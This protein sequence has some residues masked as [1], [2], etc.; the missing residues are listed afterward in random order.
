MMKKINCCIDGI[1]YKK[2][3]SAIAGNNITLEAYINLLLAEA[4]DARER[5]ETARE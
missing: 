5:K 4:L 2:L 3:Q 1:T